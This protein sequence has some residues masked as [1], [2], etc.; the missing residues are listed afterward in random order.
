LQFNPGE[1]F[2][3]LHEGVAMLLPAGQAGEDERRDAGILAKTLK[4]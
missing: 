3:V 2:Y 4:L 1:L